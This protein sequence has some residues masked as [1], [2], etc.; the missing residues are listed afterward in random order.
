[1]PISGVCRWGIGDYPIFSTIFQIKLR[2]L[3]KLYN[4]ISWVKMITQGCCS[5]RLITQPT[6]FSSSTH[7][8]LHL[9]AR[10]QNVRMLQLLWVIC[11][12]LTLF[13]SSIN[14]LCTAVL[15]SV[16]FKG[17][18]IIHRPILVLF[19]QMHT[20]A[21]RS[22]DMQALVF[23]CVHQIKRNNGSNR[24][25]RVSMTSVSAPHICSHKG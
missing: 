7:H 13:S 3:M 17:Q 5:D 14:N 21:A 4:V 18:I 2:N 11:V 24:Q 10:V 22:P 19:S 15:F 6:Y 12:I 25:Q 8:R 9:T 16:E 1:M 20:T 23:A